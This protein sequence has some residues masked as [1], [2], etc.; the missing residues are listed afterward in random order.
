ME[1]AFS[2]VPPPPSARIWRVSAVSLA[3]KEKCSWRK[4]VSGRRERPRMRGRLL[5]R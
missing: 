1:T 2:A 3:K 5:S 4:A